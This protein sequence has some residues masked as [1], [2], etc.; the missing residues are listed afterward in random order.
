MHGTSIDDMRR[1]LDHLVLG[2]IAMALGGVALRRSR[3]LAAN[4]GDVAIVEAEPAFENLGRI[5]LH[6][7]EVDRRMV[8]HLAGNRRFGS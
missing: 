6:H 8:E 3:R 4:H 1:R 5:D 2:L 7:R